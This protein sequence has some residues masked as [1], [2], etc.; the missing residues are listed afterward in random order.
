MSAGG[1]AIAAIGDIGLACT[2]LNLMIR[3]W[4]IWKGNRFVHVVLLVISLGHWIVLAL[5]VANLEGMIRPGEGCVVH[6]THANVNATV[7]VYSLCYDFIVLILTIVGLSRKKS[8][9]P[10]IT[11][12]YS[13]GVM[14]FVVTVATYITPT[15]FGFLDV[16]QMV[17][18]T[19]IC[20]MAFQL[21]IASSRAVRILLDLRDSPSSEMSE[22][23]GDTGV[24]LTSHIPVHGSMP[25]AV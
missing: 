18:M 2:S 7:F 16:E 15:V 14:Y 20:G 5:D 13:Q 1:R 24:A 11:R 10:L 21:M 9:S 6:I 19:G 22:E 8:K 12:L 17:N 25:A 4:V 23:T 3:T